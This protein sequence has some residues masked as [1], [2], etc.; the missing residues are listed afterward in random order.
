[1]QW[2]QVPL[3]HSRAGRHSLELTDA[4]AQPEAVETLRDLLSVEPEAAALDEHA[5]ALCDVLRCQNKE[6]KLMVTSAAY[7]E[8]KDVWGLIRW[9]MQHVA[10]GHTSSLPPRLQLLARGSSCWC[11]RTYSLLLIPPHA[12]A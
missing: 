5:A 4:L 9:A 8:G 3:K 10:T 7:W 2:K 6:H 11:V 1:M 12:Q